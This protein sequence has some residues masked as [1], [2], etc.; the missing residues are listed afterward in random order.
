MPDLAIQERPEARALAKLTMETIYLAASVVVEDQEGVEWATAILGELATQHKQAETLRLSFTT[1]LNA[2]LKTINVFFST[3][4]AP[5]VEADQTLRR[6]VL[7][8]REAERQR[9]LADQA[10]LTADRDA[11]EAA[12][13][14]AITNPATSLADGRQALAAADAADEALAQVPV[15]PAPTVRTALGTT[16]VRR[17][18]DFEITDLAQVPADYLQVNAEAVRT[19]IRRGVRDIPGIRI[20]EREILAVSSS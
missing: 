9:F 2:S 15:P 1:P 11:K 3:L 13:R 6:K 14:A 5:L 12:A 19:A 4:V 7:K 17:V 8:F 18:M 10:R 20:F 16:T